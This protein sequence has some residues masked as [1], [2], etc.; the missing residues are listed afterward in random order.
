MTCRVCEEG[1]IRELFDLIG[2]GWT[3]LT[4]LVARCWL[5]CFVLNV[6]CLPSGSG[7]V[8]VR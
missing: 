4:G 1:V 6:S 2:L 5:L 8:F 7:L 3:G